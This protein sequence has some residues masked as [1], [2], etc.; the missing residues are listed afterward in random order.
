M[1]INLLWNPLELCNPTCVHG[2]CNNGVCKCDAGY[3]GKACDKSKL[4]DANKAFNYCKKILMR[5]SAIS[6]FLK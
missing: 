4:T 5:M 6:T 1:K 3:N 2:T